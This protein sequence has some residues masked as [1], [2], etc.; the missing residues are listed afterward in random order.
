MKTVDYLHKYNLALFS[1]L[2]NLNKRMV[3]LE[4][5]LPEFNKVKENVE[6][7]EKKMKEHKSII[8]ENQI[9]IKELENKNKNDNKSDNINKNKE[10]E[11]EINEDKIKKYLE[12]Y[13]I[14]HNNKDIDTIKHHIN[15]INEE[16]K[17]IKI[18]YKNKN[19]ELEKKFLI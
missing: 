11:V 6:N 19:F 10:V 5:K 12:N 14:G 16:I 2:Q 7:H 18:D 17:E 4:E 1:Q 8:D 13:V 3:F 9:K 15:V